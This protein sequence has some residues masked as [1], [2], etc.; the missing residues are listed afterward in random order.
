[1]ISQLTRVAAVPNVALQGETQ[2]ANEVGAKRSLEDDP[3]SF[4]GE[5]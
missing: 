3:E 4:G 5:G 2:Y 1:L